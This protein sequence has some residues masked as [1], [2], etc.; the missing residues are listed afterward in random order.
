MLDVA[1]RQWSA[2]VLQAVEMD[3][4]LLPALY[5]S[6]QVCGQ[7]SAIG[8]EATGLVLERL[9]SPEAETSLLEQSEWESS[10]R[11]QSGATIEHR[12]WYLLPRTYPC[13]ILRPF[14][15]LLPCGPRAL[16]M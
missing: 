14:A 11:A 2:E 8:A 6:P 7:V 1:N 4:A 15:H 12:E 13:A 9:L 5:E 3:P 16:G 10:R